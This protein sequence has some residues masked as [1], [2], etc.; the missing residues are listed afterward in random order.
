MADASVV[1]C[2][3]PPGERSAGDL[4][5]V[6]DQLTVDSF[7][8]KISVQWAPQEAVTPLGQ[9]PFFIDFLKQSGL[10]EQLVREAPLSY[11]SPDAPR[12]RDVLGTLVL[13]MVAGG[14][15]YAHVNALRYDGVNPE[16]L[17]MKRVCS[18]DSVRA[19][20]GA[21]GRGGGGAVA[22]PAAGV[23]VA[24][25]VAAGLDPRRGHD[26]EAAVRAAGGGA[27][28]VQPAQAGA[29]GAGD[30]CVRDGDDAAGAGSRGGG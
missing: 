20:G 26:G 15:R 14:R 18:D 6:P 22:V 21:T 11:T 8:G 2:A 3:H 5:A 17:G 4:E 28:R 13:S 16:L 24:A 27:S 1:P 30:P 9:L 10:F 7:A 23:C 12:P 25:A 19:G 29:A